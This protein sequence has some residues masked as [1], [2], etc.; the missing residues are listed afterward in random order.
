MQKKGIF[1][2]PGSLVLCG[3]GGT[4]G[5]LLTLETA[6]SAN[7]LAISFELALP[8]FVDFPLRP[9]NTSLPYAPQYTSEKLL[10]SVHTVSI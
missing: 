7:S 2:L 4:I 6:C 10:K 1:K 9:F 3:L 8:S 5:F